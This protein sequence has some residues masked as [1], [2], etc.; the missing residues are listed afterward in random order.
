MA[1]TGRYSY[2]RQ[3]ASISELRR[4]AVS[5][6]HVGDIRSTL[7]TRFALLIDVSDLTTW[8]LDGGPTFLTGLLRHRTW[9]CLGWEARGIPSCHHPAAR[10]VIGPGSRAVC[11]PETRSAR[12]S[13]TRDPAQRCQ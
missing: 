2:H 4:D 11:V 5:G 7:T 6:I 12:A 9:N 10:V 1:A 8:L 13:P 3:A